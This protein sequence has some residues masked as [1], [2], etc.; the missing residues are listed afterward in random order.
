MALAHTH[1]NR[2]RHEIHKNPMVFPQNF[3]L[4]W[5]WW[6]FNDIWWVPAGIDCLIGSA[7]LCCVWDG[8]LLDSLAWWSQC[9]FSSVSKLADFIGSLCV[10]HWEDRRQVS[11]NRILTTLCGFKTMRS[12][13]T[14]GLKLKMCRSSHSC[15]IPLTSNDENDDG[16]DG[17]E[18]KRSAKR[19][20]K[21]KREKM[22]THEFQLGTSAKWSWTIQCE[23]HT[24]NNGSTEAPSTCPELC[25]QFSGRVHGRL[26]FV[27][28]MN[29]DDDDGDGCDDENDDDDDRTK[30]TFIQFPC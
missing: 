27:W 8:S 18:Q 22:A 10:S 26:L 28:R 16:L 1:T 15:G 19:D 11:I 23:P 7:Y 9:R 12:I 13:T 5:K 6:C 4:I 3:K 2:H 20:R 29:D 24:N 14:F 25:T 17:M 30:S 21:K